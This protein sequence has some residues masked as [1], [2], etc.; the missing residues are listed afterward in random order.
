MWALQPDCTKYCTCTEV[1]GATKVTIGKKPSDHDGNFQNVAS[2]LWGP[3][4]EVG[5]QPCV[6]DQIVPLKIL[7]VIFGTESGG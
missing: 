4:E 1:C 7:Q 6:C 5:N 3:K 2:H